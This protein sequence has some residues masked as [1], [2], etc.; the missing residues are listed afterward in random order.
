MLADDGLMAR[1]GG[2]EEKMT[3]KLG[4]NWRG[5]DAGENKTKTKKTK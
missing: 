1:E 2:G 5:K 4:E 3:R